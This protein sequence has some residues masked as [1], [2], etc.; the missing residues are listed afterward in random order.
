MPDHWCNR[1]ESRTYRKPWCFSKGSLAKKKNIQIPWFAFNQ[2]TLE[3]KYLQRERYEEWAPYPF[4][5][6][7]M[8]HQQPVV[9]NRD[10]PQQPSRYESLQTAWSTQERVARS[11]PLKPKVRSVRDWE[12]KQ[13]EKKSCRHRETWGNSPQALLSP[14]SSWYPAVPTIWLQCKWVRWYTWWFLSTRWSWIK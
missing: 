7:A 12:H 10:I 3:A 5:K 6:K 13:N 9:E 4:L 1:T 11:T 8:R 2:G 14:A